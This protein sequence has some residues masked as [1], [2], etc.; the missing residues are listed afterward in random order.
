MPHASESA[1]RD[2]ETLWLLSTISKLHQEVLRCLLAGSS[3]KGKRDMIENSLKNVPK[4]RENI[5]HA[6]RPPIL[7]FRKFGQITI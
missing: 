5:T 1:E 7:Q 2:K 6:R 3:E 4:R